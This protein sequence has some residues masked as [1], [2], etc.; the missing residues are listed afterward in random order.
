ML[1]GPSLPRTD[2]RR[3]GCDTGGIHLLT[4]IPAVSGP[5]LVADLGSTVLTPST[6]PSQGRVPP[7]PFPSVRRRAGLSTASPNIHSN[8]TVFT[9]TNS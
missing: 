2:H 1:G 3:A 8:P 7:C 6:G 4:R 5:A 9:L